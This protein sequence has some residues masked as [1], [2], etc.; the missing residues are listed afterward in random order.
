MQTLG[1]FAITPQ[2]EDIERLDRL[3]A[4][5][6]ARNPSPETLSAQQVAEYNT[7]GYLS[8]FRIFSNAEIEDIR[9][10][11]DTLLE[12]VME[13]GMDSYSISSAHLK[14]GDAYDLLTDSRIVAYVSDLLGENVIGWGSHYFCKMPRDGKSV[15]WHQDAS[16]WPLTPAKTVTVWLAIDDAD[17]ENACMRF[18][19]ASHLRGHIEFEKSAN[20]E[21]NVLNQ[22]VAD[23]GRFGDPVDNVLQAGEISLHS[24]LL[25]HASD[26]NESDRR[27]C[28]MTLRYCAASVKAHLNWNRKGVVVRGGNPGGHWANPARPDA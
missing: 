20:A 24:D 22:T 11:F 13:A 18:I 23:I 5:Y 3:I 12:A 14:Y 15:S 28:A 4:F 25:L 9:S 27:R 16:Y 21:A 6:P 7:K 1:K 8:G 26:A 10:R 17:T 2:L 19:P